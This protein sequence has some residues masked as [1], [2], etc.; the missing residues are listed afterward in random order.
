MQQTG[1]KVE[2]KK[3]KT[4]SRKQFNNPTMNTKAEAVKQNAEWI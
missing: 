2:K 3:N 1:S 4:N